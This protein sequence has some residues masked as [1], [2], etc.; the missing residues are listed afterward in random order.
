MFRRDM[1][2]ILR[3]RPIST[4]ELA[5]RHE[6]KPRDLEDELQHLFR[7][8]RKDLLCPAITPATWRKCG[9]RF[10]GRKL[11]KPGICPSCKGSWI[12]ELL[13]FLE[14]KLG[15]SRLRS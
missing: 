14:E 6:E 8:L 1:I 4:H 7:S 10:D 2:D 3:G 5:K 15:V 13:I 11:Y 9:L 12:S